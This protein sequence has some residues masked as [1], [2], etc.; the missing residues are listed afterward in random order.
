MIAALA[1]RR[2]L[3]LEWLVWLR[4]LLGPGRDAQQRHD[5]PEAWYRESKVSPEVST[6]GYQRRISSE[7]LTGRIE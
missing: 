5:Q 3:R 2:L 1:L 7:W 4:G 6:T